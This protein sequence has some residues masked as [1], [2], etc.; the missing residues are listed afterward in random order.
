MNELRFA[1]VTPQRR[2]RYESE[3]RQLVQA[4]KRRDAGG[5]REMTIAH[6]LGVKRNLLAR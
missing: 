2:I 6:L 4:I 5:A 1:T 3:H